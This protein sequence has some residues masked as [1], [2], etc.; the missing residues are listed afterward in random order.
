M[1]VA[2][3]AAQGHVQDPNGQPKGEAVI[4]RAF[5]LCLHLGPDFARGASWGVQSEGESSN[6][7]IIACCGC[8]RDASLIF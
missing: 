1:L 6:Q 4:S 8:W 3:W 2:P 5:G 7:S